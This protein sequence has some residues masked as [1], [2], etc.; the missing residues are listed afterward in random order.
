[1]PTA[2]Q[3]AGHSV[4]CVSLASV[5]YHS[6]VAPL[7]AAASATSVSVAAASTPLS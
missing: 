2:V 1:L 5:Q 4:T 3:V 6:L 7:H